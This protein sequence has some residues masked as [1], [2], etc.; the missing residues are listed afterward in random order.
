MKLSALLQ[1]DVPHSHTSTMRSSRNK[2]CVPEKGGSIDVYVVKAS[3]AGC[4]L[5]SI[6]RTVEFE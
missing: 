2:K 1:S 3:R 5:A 6:M 4:L